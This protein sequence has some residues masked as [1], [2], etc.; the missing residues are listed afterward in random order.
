M[1]LNYAVLCISQYN[2]HNIYIYIIYNGLK[3]LEIRNLIFLFEP[4]RSM[5]SLIIVID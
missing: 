2:I 3:E 1:C 5:P 4:C